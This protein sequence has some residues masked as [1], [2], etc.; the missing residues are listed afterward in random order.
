MSCSQAE[1]RSAGLFSSNMVLQRDIPVP[2]W[3]TAS[4]GEQV[5]VSF[6]G[7]T[8][9]AA[10]DEQGRWSLNLQPM[11]ACST[12]AVL[13]V[14]GSRT[15][16]FEN[17]LVG[18][19]W[20]CSGQSN[21]DHSM[22]M[23]HLPEEEIQAATNYPQLRL[24]KVDYKTNP[25][26][27]EAEVQ[28]EWA[29][30]GYEAAADFSATAAY[31]GRALCRD[32][33]VP[34]G[35]IHSAW[36]GTPAGSWTSREMLEQ[37][38]FMV[39]KLQDADCA[40]RDYDPAA[41]QADYERLLAEW[42]QKKEAGGDP[43]FEPQLWNPHT[44]PWMPA[45]LYNGMI[46]PLVPMAI[47]GVIWY[48]G[49]ANAGWHWVY[50]E[51]FGA[52]IEDWRNHWGQPFSPEAAGVSLGNFPF[53]FVQ[54]ANF[55]ERQTQPVESVSS[56]WP[57]LRE[58]QQQVLALP[59]TAMAVT[60]DV[61]EADDIHPRDKKSVGERL[62][63]AA[64]ALAYG[65]DLVFSGPLFQGL[66]IRGHEAILS[67]D[68]TGSGLMV[69]GETLKGFAVRGERGGWH[70]GEARTDGH[71]V[72]VSADEVPEPVAVRYNWA[73]NPVGNLYNRE[74]LPAAPFRSDEDWYFEPTRDTP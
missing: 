26:Q 27:P 53:L 70:W 66:E 20:L 43:G 59:N 28:G 25:E 32:L 5:T 46:A 14:R 45:T 54:L 41:A 73:N 3:G 31:F 38:P 61:G 71:T 42:K 1:M 44:S 22:R 2:V 68:H 65:E 23:L 72:V 36:G 19:V 9:S 18:D 51:S 13:T 49:E 15:Q 52:L 11:P 48:Q 17:V 21:M 6:H 4:P 47:R 34:I 10:A 69:K 30:S 39:G 55:M 58:A 62:A 67:F 35:L 7:Q 50:R 60:T 37:L 63:L 12:G 33:D 40:I 24:F 29:V 57:Y 74:G 56:T 16:A 8:V 64:R